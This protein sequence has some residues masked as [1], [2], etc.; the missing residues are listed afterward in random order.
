MYKT[1]E[2]IANDVL[3]KLAAGGP[4]V[5]Q[6]APSPA[7]QETAPT[8]ERNYVAPT[9]AGLAGAGVGHMA[10]SGI[11]VSRAKKSAP[12]ATRLALDHARSQLGG[13]RGRRAANALLQ[14]TRPWS[15]GG[16]LLGLGAGVGLYNLLRD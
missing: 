12:R 1:A 13:Q 14:R 8:P 16:A 11:G 2:Q 10:G 5:Q 15:R 6:A 4:A 7:E 9:L 3:E